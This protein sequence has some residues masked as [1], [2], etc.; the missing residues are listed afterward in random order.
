MSKEH[1]TVGFVS[2]TPDRKVN[3]DI[4]KQNSAPDDTS[5]SSLL[6]DTKSPDTPTFDAFG[7]VRVKGKGFGCVSTKAL[8]PCT[9]LLDE[10]GVFVDYCGVAAKGE[11]IERLTEVMCLERPDCRA[12]YSADSHFRA[13]LT[14]S[15][16]SGGTVPDWAEDLKLSPEEWATAKSQVH[17][18]AIET[19]IPSA[20]PT[21]D[22]SA[23][24]K[25]ADSNPPATTASALTTSAPVP[26][27][28]SA[29]SAS[30][31][32]PSAD[33]RLAL[34]PIT[35]RFNHSCEP[36]C[37][38]FV[39]RH[40]HSVV[41]T[42]TAVP[43]GTEL[44]IGYVNELLLQSTS[45]RQHELWT[46]HE[47]HCRCDRCLRTS[48]SLS[49]S[50]RRLHAGYKLLYRPASTTSP[51]FIAERVFETFDEWRLRLDEHC[52]TILCTDECTALVTSVNAVI[53][54]WLEVAAERGLPRYCSELFQI[55]FRLIDGFERLMRMRY[56]SQSSNALITSESGAATATA[57]GP[58]SLELLYCLLASERALFWR[59]LR[60]QL[61][62]MLLDLK[63]QPTTD[64]VLT[65]L[66][67]YQRYL[68]PLLPVAKPSAAARTATVSAAASEDEHIQAA[69]ATVC[70][71]PFLD[72]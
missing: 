41:Y 70:S 53:E 28:A 45:V 21:A 8:A 35:A 19:R 72:L 24:C 65:A 38:M 33:T 6:P 15:Y 39:N 30:S 49:H 10:V 12:L 43:T 52:D 56:D 18:N 23:T 71:F 58:D 54:V 69:C 29:S 11:A 47:F 16:E 67:L 31:S 64:C 27:V 1:A 2:Q 59:L 14:E 57:E 9:L 63:W 20:P 66:K 50:D 48:E 3:N 37:G 40:G 5:S 61:D 7:V 36:N 34:F 25:V 60:E 22:T 26:L 42:V 51:S 4:G 17:T 32:S 68:P 46:S 62:A 13:Y 55:R 44:C